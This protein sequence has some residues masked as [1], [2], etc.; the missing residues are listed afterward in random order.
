MA[1]NRL[2]CGRY[3]P[4]DREDASEG[5]SYSKCIEQTP[6]GPKHAESVPLLYAIS[7]WLSHS[8]A[9]SSTLSSHPAT[10]ALYEVYLPENMPRL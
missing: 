1:R 9:G 4:I 3:R 8:T 10:Q 2:A 5:G 6:E 7:V